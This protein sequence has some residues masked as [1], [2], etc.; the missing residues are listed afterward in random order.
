M[1][2]ARPFPT[3]AEVAARLEQLRQLYELG[4]ALREARFVDPS[5][6]LRPPHDAGRVR[7]RDAGPSEGRTDARPPTG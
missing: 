7:E 5:E 1:S 3:P 6:P 4:I 2:D